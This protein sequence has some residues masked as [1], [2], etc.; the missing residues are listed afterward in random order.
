MISNLLT[1]K[2]A[3]ISGASRGIG[4]GIALRFAK[5]GASL[6]LICLKN[7]ES[8]NEVSKEAMAM[9]AKTLNIIGD[10]SDVSFCE[11]VL[12]KT[13]SEFDRVDILVNCAGIITRA[14]FEDMSLVDWHKVIN[15]N[16]H[17]TFNLCR[18]FLPIM[19]KQNNGKV[20]NVTSQMAF[21]PHP[22]ASP[23][24]EVSKAAIT[25]LTRHLSFQYAKY[26]VCIN[27][28]APGSIDTDLPKSMSEEARAK[29]KSAI[30]MKRLVETEEVGDSA[31]FLA[32]SMS[33]YVTGT[34]LHINGG[35]LML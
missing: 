19:R 15:V 3:V 23:S 16:L 7:K 14:P 2:I 32:S 24:Y 34:T 9:G 26:N 31:L 13:I 27:A 22:G 20:I 29:L 12:E 5:E 4:K 17:G 33:G 8:L 30:P 1:N 6:V 25:A 28:I 21:L 18:M 10:V 35:S 11:S